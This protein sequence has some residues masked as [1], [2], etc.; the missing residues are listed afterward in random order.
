MSQAESPAGLEGTGVLVGGSDAVKVTCLTAA[1]QQVGQ[2]EGRGLV[3]CLGVR[4]GLGSSEAND[5]PVVW[6]NV[7]FLHPSKSVLVQVA[8]R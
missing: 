2:D 5:R 1:G 7:W 4:D 6:E 3:C 8:R